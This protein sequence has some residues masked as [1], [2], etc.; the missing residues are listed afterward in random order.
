[1]RVAILGCGLAGLSAAWF[2]RQQGAEVV[3]LDRADGPARETSFANGAL[4]TPSLADPWN[5]PGSA[6]TLLR[7]LGR[8]DAA[9]KIRLKALPSLLFW[10]LSFLRN[11]SLARFRESFLA[12]VRLAVHSQAVMAGLLQ[13]HP[14]QFDYAPNGTVK[15]YRDQAGFRQGR[16]VADWLATEIPHQ[17]LDREQLLAMEPAL[18]P[19]ADRLAGAIH[20]PQDEVG[21]AR[22]F[23]EEL[24]RLAEAKGVAFRFGEPVTSVERTGRRIAALITAKERLQADQFVL[25]AGSQSWPLGRQFGL[26]LPIRP[27]KGYSITLP[28]GEAQPKLNRPVLDDALHAAVVPLGEKLIRVA[29]TAEFTGFDGR[30]NP[31]R[32]RNLEHLLAQVLPEFRYAAKDV[33]GWC[34]FRPMTPDGRPII[35]HTPI[36]NLYLNT[37]HG[38]LGWTQACGSG[39]AL[40][41]LMTGQPSETDLVPFGYGRF[42]RLA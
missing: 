33:Q 10:G 7:S 3:A 24:R 42:R 20:F 39:Q 11:S 41:R 40:A 2:L 36:E 38:P 32:I 9:L 31:H 28:A 35:G 13:S 27:A 22:L 19:I 15:I 34:G 21:N 1:M 29:G 18:A 16:E 17:V 8:E 26:R 4:L 12:N 23:C 25:A 30:L 37:G 5:A 14:L 6:G